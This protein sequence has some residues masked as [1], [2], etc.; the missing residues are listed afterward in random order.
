MTSRYTVLCGRTLVA[1]AVLRHVCVSHGTT[2]KR[3]WPEY[4]SRALEAHIT[5]APPAPG[6]ETARPAR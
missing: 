5:A 1:E 6:E 4:M 3:P 2:E